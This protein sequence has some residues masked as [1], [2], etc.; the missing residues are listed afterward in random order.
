MFPTLNSASVILNPIAC[1]FQ[2]GYFQT[3][4]NS[5]TTGQ[6]RYFELVI[7]DIPYGFSDEDIFHESKM[8]YPTLLSTKRITNKYGRITTYFSGSDS[9]VSGPGMT[10][11]V[12]AYISIICA[13]EVKN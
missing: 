13:I 11:S 2:P 9:L 1:E 12:M 8:A 7:C 3:G 10:F 5:Q 4:S 6:N